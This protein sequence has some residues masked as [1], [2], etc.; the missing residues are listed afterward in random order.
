MPSPYRAVCA[1]LSPTSAPPGRQHRRPEPLAHSRVPG[2]YTPM[3]EPQ[4]RPGHQ[5]EGAPGLALRQAAGLTLPPHRLKSREIDPRQS[6]RE[7]CSTE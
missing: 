1:A 5:V 2:Y 7:F 4:E 3:D 6:R